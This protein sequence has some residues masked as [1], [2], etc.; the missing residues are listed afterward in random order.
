[1]STIEPLSTDAFGIGLWRNAEE[2]NKDVKNYAMPI[3]GEVSQGGAGF[4][5][6]FGDFTTI[7]VGEPIK[8]PPMPRALRGSYGRPLLN[9]PDDRI[10]LLS[11]YDSPVF[12]D[13][14][15]A[16]A[17]ILAMKTYKESINQ[18]TQWMP[19]PWGMS[20]YG[21]PIFPVDVERTLEENGGIVVR[22]D[23]SEFVAID[24]YSKGIFGDRP[25]PPWEGDIIN[26]DC[27]G[28]GGGGSTRPDYGLLYPRKV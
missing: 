15:L 17:A 1:M 14:N 21:R 27:A 11:I 7:N 4:N 19:Y 18:F 13:H 23:S 25:E 20:F 5:P 12:A 6:I 26:P 16:D 2:L 28:G 8:A 10:T 24:P 9:F 3:F 22:S